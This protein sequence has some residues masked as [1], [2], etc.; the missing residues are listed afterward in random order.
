MQHITVISL[1]N[2]LASAIKFEF[3]DLIRNMKSCGPCVSVSHK[4]V[5]RRC[6]N[7]LQ[8][9][10]LQQHATLS[11]KQKH[12]QLFSQIIDNILQEYFTWFMQRLNRLTKSGKLKEND[13]SLGDESL[14]QLGQQL[15]GYKEFTYLKSFLTPIDLKYG[16]PF[17]DSE[18][19]LDHWSQVFVDSNGSVHCVYGLRYE[20]YTRC[21]YYNPL[22][23]Q[24]FSRRDVML[25]LH[26]PILEEYDQRKKT[27]LLTN[28]GHTLNLT[29]LD[30][31]FFA[32]NEQTFAGTP[33]RTVPI[34]NIIITED[35]TLYDASEYVEWL[36]KSFCLLNPL[37]LQPFRYT[38]ALLFTKHPMVAMQLQK[39][40]A[41]YRDC[42]NAL[43]SKTLY[44]IHKLQMQLAKSYPTEVDFANIPQAYSAGVDDRL[45]RF[46]RYFETLGAEE[47]QALLLLPVVLRNDN[48]RLQA[49][50]F[51]ELYAELSK[52][53]FH[54]AEMS[55]WLLALLCN[56]PNGLALRAVAEKQQ[57]YDVSDLLATM[58]PLHETEKKTVVEATVQPV[59]LFRPERKASFLKRLLK[60]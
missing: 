33:T 7:D 58:Q 18:V 10:H 47:Q 2:L 41:L 23:T 3:G 8:R 36:Q 53:Q 11:Q 17:A 48:G 1:R 12:L 42:Q 29:L 60:H 30:R 51:G 20:F 37:S 45:K 15:S 25:L 22:S 44:K 55:R 35:Y 59:A 52:C 50:S 19:D 34:P 56:H 39:N 57:Y 40:M 31:L 21:R 38:D 43:S 46:D 14:Y 27:E 13:K 28:Y 16:N 6:S 32:K 24:L 49:R 9:M 26:N 54:P 4:S 5:L